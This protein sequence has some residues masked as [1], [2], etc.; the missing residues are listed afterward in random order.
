MRGERARKGTDGRRKGSEG[1]GPICRKREG[2]QVQGPEGINVTCSP[3]EINQ[4]ANAPPPNQRQAPHPKLFSGGSSQPM[5]SSI[6]VHSLGQRR[7]RRR[8]T[9]SVLSYSPDI[10]D[11]RTPRPQTQ[12][13]GHTDTQAQRHSTTDGQTQTRT[14]GSQREAPRR[15][16][17]PPARIR[18]RD[19]PRDWPIAWLGCNVIVS[20]S[21]GWR[22]RWLAMSGRRGYDRHTPR[23]SWLLGIRAVH[24]GERRLATVQM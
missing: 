13:A 21:F 14:T 23:Q 16:A 4:W 1:R 5:C 18:D 8:G 15:G 7:R 24:S 10:T 9:P 20:Q 19:A 17:P 2:S 11:T 6:C 12:T 3:H 22:R